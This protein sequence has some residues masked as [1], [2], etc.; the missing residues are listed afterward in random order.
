MSSKVHFFL[1]AI[2]FLGLFS[3]K[4]EMSTNL[5]VPDKRESTHDKIMRIDTLQISDN[6][7]GMGC[8]TEY[9]EK[10][11]DSRKVI[12]IQTGV[13]NSEKWVSYISIDG[14]KEK[15]YSN[16][17]QDENKSNEFGDAYSLKLENETYIVEIHAKIGDVNIESDSAMA[18]GTI[19]ITRKLDKK[20]LSIEFEGGTAC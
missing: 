5:A 18:S 9:Y 12:Y 1:I 4:K 20:I 14:K 10:G 15:F 16:N 3:C 2:F 13:D 19:T 6:E 17:V 7:I 11:S 8:I